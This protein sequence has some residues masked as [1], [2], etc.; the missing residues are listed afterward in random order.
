MGKSGRNYFGTHVGKLY[1]RNEA[2]ARGRYMGE[3]LDREQGHHNEIL[4][5]RPDTPPTPGASGSDEHPTTPVT[6]RTS[7]VRLDTRPTPGDTSTE[8]RPATPPTP[9]TPVVEDPLDGSP[10]SPD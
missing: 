1:E 9:G 7:V 5:V 2:S 4:V 3:F 6:L 10:G 8:A